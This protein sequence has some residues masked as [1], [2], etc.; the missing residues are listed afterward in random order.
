MALSVTESGPGGGSEKTRGNNVFRLRFENTE[1]QSVQML[2]S[3]YSRDI[4]RRR[5][6]TVAF[7]LG[8]LY[9]QGGRLLDTVKKWQYS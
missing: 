9:I 4:M 7:L 6:A 3:A 5:A 8:T 2:L 1:T